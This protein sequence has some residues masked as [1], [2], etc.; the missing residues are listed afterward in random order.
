MVVVAVV[1]VLA[2]VQGDGGAI[3]DLQAGGWHGSRRGG[4]QGAGDAAVHDQDGCEGQQVPQ[5]EVGCVVS[6]LQRQQ[7]QCSQ[8]LPEVHGSQHDWGQY[9]TCVCMNLL[10]WLYRPE[11]AGVN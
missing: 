5:H 7:A 9:S 8:L 2:G 1:A 10:L 3:P 4:P 11:H 6:R